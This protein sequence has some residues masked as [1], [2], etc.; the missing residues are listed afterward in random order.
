MPVK[1]MDQS[2]KQEVAWKFK[3]NEDLNA[4]LLKMSKITSSLSGLLVEC[5]CLRIDS[6]EGIDDNLRLDMREICIRA[7]PILIFPGEQSSQ[8]SMRTSDK[9]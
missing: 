9:R 5:H 2:L 7:Q 8:V 6:S 4:R 1:S 3:I